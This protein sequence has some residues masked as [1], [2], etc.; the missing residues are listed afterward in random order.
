[1]IM[2]GCFRASPPLE[3]D[4]S[5][6]PVEVI[7]DAQPT[8]TPEPSPTPVAAP[9]SPNNSPLIMQ[10]SNLSIDEL[11]TYPTLSFRIFD[12]DD[13]VMCKNVIPVSNN[14]STIR[15]TSTGTQN[16]TAMTYGDITITGG[17]STGCGI[18]IT[19]RYASLSPVGITLSLGDGKTVSQSSFSVQVKSTN[20]APQVI[21]SGQ[22]NVT[23]SEDQN[24]AIAIMLPQF[25][26]N[27]ARG[28]PARMN[29]EVL[30]NPSKGTLGSWPSD[31]GAAGTSITYTPAPDANGSDSFSYRV[32]DNDPGILQCSPAQTV[33]LAITPVNDLPA[34]SSIS[35]ASVKESASTSVSFTISDADNTVSCSS[36]VSY[37]STNTTLVAA[38]VQAPASSAITF[39]GTASNCSASITPTPNQSGNTTLNFTVSDGT[40]TKSASFLLTVTPINHAPTISTIASPQS[41]QEET[42]LTLN[43]TASDPDKTYSCSSPYLS[44]ASTNTTLI[45]SNAVVWSGTWPSC[46]AEITPAANQTGSTQLTF[47]VTDDGVAT[48]ST[49]MSVSTVFTLQ[50][51]N[52]NDAPTGTISCGGSSTAEVRLSG[53]NSGAWSLSCSG[54]SDID[55][56]DTLTYKM[57]YQSDQDLSGYT[58][59]ATITSTTGT[60]S[61]TY[62]ATPN[63]GTCRYKVQACDAASVCTAYSSF[64]VELNHYQL[65]ISSV[66]K[67]TLSATSSTVCTVSSQAT[68]SKSGNINSFSHSGNVKF[69]GASAKTGSSSNS[70]TSFSDTFT[71][72]YLIDSPPAR[73]KS[74]TSIS[75]EFSVSNISFLSGINN[76]ATHI[77]SPAISAVSS[78]Y[79]IDRTLEDLKARNIADHSNSISESTVNLDGYQPDYATTSSVCR[80]CT[81]NL[82]SLTAA[83]G[84]SCLIDVSTLKCWGGNSS[85]QLGTANTTT[86]NFPQPISI[87]AFTPLQV[88]AGSDFTCTLGN[89]S[90]TREIRC[91]GNNTLGQLGRSSGATNSFAAAINF[92]TRT[93]VAIASAKFGQFSC[94]I[95]ND[96]GAST[97]GHVH[98]WGLNTSGQL[99]NGS[100]STP[101]VGTVVAV[102]K[103]AFSG[104]NANVFALATGFQHTCAIQ[105]Q[106]SGVNAV[107]CWGDGS[108]GK[109]GHNSLSNSSVPVAVDASQLG[110]NVLQIAAGYNHT[111]ALRSGGDVFCWGDNSVGQ[112]GIGST[113]ST[114][115]PAQ[116]SGIN[117]NAVQITAGAN[118]TCALLNNFSVFCWGLG[119][120]GQLGVGS[121]TTNDQSV[122]DCN[123]GIGAVNVT[124]CKKSPTAVTFPAAI[125]SPSAA[126]AV[127]SISAGEAHTC[128][129]SIQGT[130]YCWGNNTSGQLGTSNTQQVSSP[131]YICNSSASCN[132]STQLTSPRPRMCSKY[133]IP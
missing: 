75:A 109:L 119:N 59:P 16:Q 2:T 116:V 20:T 47:T 85:A 60:L 77:P 22:T 55:P 58:C 101:A 108:L 39:S 95:L 23:L 35:N 105:N 41:T 13:T 104:S 30:T 127:V 93:P 32:C 52:T 45:P 27:T 129:L 89:G 40:N 113:T 62:T 21:V 91:A 111:C 78:S 114:S 37:T 96:S 66:T 4:E 126:P 46:T 117:A 15:T 120:T 88:A 56:G 25:Q 100:T 65:S 79:A 130:S 17:E 98:C 34:I 74:Q 53:R 3:D 70:P 54:A 14:I 6:T 121:V 31:P 43:F 29:F 63:Y 69:T 61:G 133:V 71:G 107:Y 49:V 97:S 18:A 42:K 8:S 125:I 11:T 19:T 86:Y 131:A 50:V 84:H 81:G 24:P 51:T 57:E 112:L 64:S 44:F 102:S 132:A 1:M 82:A 80:L 67:P 90:S 33:N 9:D 87:S 28:T 122:D 10:I 94:A 48:D 128:A 103:G 72:T 7:V 110:T 5:N 92:S 123:S 38:P 83:S 68:F 26:D 106:G 76:N 118:H 115:V 124:F 99:G 36:S 73:D 12:F